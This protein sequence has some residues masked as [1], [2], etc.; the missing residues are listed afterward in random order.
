[1]QSA[2]MG[3]GGYPS[4]RLETGGTIWPVSINY[5]D[6]GEIIDLIDSLL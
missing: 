5:N 1:M 6:A 2:D 3:V 4:L